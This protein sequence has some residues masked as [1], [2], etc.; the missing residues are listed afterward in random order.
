ML[1]AGAFHQGQSLGPSQR[2]TFVQ[3][4]PQENLALG[5][6]VNTNVSF[7]PVF[8]PQRLTDGGTGNLD[9]FLGYP[10][11]PEPVVVTVDLEAECLLDRVVVHAYSS[12]ES[13][14]TYALDLSVDGKT[15]AKVG[16]RLDA[17]PETATPTVHELAGAH[18]R[19][20]RIRS[21]GQPGQ[22]FASFSRLTEIQAFGSRV[23]SG[24]Q[25]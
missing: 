9:Y 8:C 13:Y 1:R 18:A 16:E 3:V 4:E 14:E 17:P 20:L 22:V 23:K 21:F 7:G 11:R 12:G 25:K 6:A 5:K 24:A 10:A 2:R 15:W 19:F